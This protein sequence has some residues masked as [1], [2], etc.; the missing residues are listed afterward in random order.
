MAKTIA[1]KR[2]TPEAYQEALSAYVANELAARALAIKRDKEVARLDDKYNPVFEEYMEQQKKYSAIVQGYCASNREALFAAGK[3]IKTNSYD[4]G[5]RSGKVKVD[6][7][8]GITEEYALLMLK[9]NLPGYVRTVEQI[10][11][12]KL[13]SDREQPNVLVAAAQCGLKFVAD[14]LFFIKVKEGTR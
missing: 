9:K 13:I 4:V 12:D 14:E 7:E 6:L 2:V 11:K 5:Y 10:A 1:K 3:V 8:D